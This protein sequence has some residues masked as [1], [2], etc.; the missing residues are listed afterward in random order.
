MIAN[1]VRNAR[2]DSEALRKP[3]ILDRHLT[4]RRVPGLLPV[5]A[6]RYSALTSE[7]VGSYATHP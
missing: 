7:V 3:A 1:V 4:K 2:C 5:S 6:N